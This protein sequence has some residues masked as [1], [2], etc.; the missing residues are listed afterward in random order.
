MAIPTVPSARAAASLIPSPIIATRLVFILNSPRLVP[1]SPPEAPRVGREGERRPPSTGSLSVA[2]L[3]LQDG[4]GNG[5]NTVP[6]ADSTP[7]PGRSPSGG[8]LSPLERITPNRRQPIRS[9]V[10]RAG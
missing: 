6:T 3:S 7:G 5:A 2:V 8:Q 4:C 10:H 9:R 1:V